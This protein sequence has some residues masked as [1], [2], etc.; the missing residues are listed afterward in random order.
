MIPSETLMLLVE[1]KVVLSSTPQG[2]EPRHSF[3]Y[4][5]VEVALPLSQVLFGE[6]NFIRR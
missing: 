1:I 2:R 4:F 3:G 5:C 6:L